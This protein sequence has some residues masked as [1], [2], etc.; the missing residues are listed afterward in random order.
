MEIRYSTLA[1]VE[2]V[3][4]IDETDLAALYDIL[5]DYFLSMLPYLEMNRSMEYQPEKKAIA[6]FAKKFGVPIDHP[7]SLTAFY[8][9]A[10]GRRHDD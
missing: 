3:V 10:L 6:E 1:P 7:P 5:A 4:Q 8:C 2:R 9:A